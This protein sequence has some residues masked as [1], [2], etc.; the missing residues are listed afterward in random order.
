MFQN[1]C[2]NVEESLLDICDESSHTICSK[3]DETVEAMHSDYLQSIQGREVSP[4]S[5]V[6][7]SEIQQLL[8]RVHSSFESGQFDPFFEEMPHTAQNEKVTLTKQEDEVTPIKQEDDVFP[9][10]QEDVSV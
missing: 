9:I 1:S 3:I 5:R 6:V 10:K 8:S 2:R 7:R 4:A